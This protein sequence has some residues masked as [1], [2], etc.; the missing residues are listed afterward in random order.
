M[1]LREQYEEHSERDRLSVPIATYHLK[2]T[3]IPP[4]WHREIELIQPNSPGI[5]EL[6]GARLPFSAND[7]LCINKGVLHRTSSPL[8]EADLLVLDLRILLSPLLAQDEACFLNRLE[9][10]QMLLPDHVSLVGKGGTEIMETFQKCICQ[11]QKKKAGWELYTQTDLLHLLEL[12]WKY[13]YLIET[14]IHSVNTQSAVVKES[15]LFMRY[16]AGEHLDIEQLAKNAALSPSHYIRAFRRYT[17]QTP[18]AFLNDIRLEQAVNLLQ[19][20]KNVTDTA[21]QVGISNINYFI[22]LFRRK[23][24]QTP[25][26]YQLSHL[27]TARNTE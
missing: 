23:Y 16:H 22:R 13:G 18:I 24:G 26:Q 25:K 6:E 10:G 4:H 5:I 15:I 3:A 19:Q 1:I 9:A 14:G 27:P 12:L 20:G 11:I 7:L 2:Q 8:D 21:L 17:G